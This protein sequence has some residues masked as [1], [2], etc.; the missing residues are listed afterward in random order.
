MLSFVIPVFNE[1]ESLNPL[2]AEIETV[3]V[4]HGFDYEVIFIDDGSTDG[5]WD[6]IVEQQEHDPRVLGIQFRR[7]FGN[8]K[9]RAFVGNLALEQLC[10]KAPSSRIGPAG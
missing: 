9:L 4:Q 6:V 1:E 5:S 10:G 8:L 3:S 2:V 7:N